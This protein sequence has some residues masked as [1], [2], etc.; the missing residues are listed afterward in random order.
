MRDFVKIAGRRYEVVLVGSLRRRGR[1]RPW[2]VC[3]RTHRVYV[4][5]GLDPADRS[6]AVAY[7]VASGRRLATARAG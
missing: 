4:N 2:V 7:A 1:E 3:H 6:A 5:R